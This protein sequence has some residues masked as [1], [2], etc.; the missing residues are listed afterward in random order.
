MHSNLAQFQEAYV[1][2]NDLYIVT[3]FVPSNL[4]ELMKD[5]AEVLPTCVIIKIA[6]QIL[7]ALSVNFK[8]SM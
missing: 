1:Q 5:Y 8:V 4:H 7:S 2:G 6:T 3:E